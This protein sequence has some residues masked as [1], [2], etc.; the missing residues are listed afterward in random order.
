M[1]VVTGS[2]RSGTSAVAR[3]LHESG[4]CMGRDLIGPTEFNA[5][6]YYEE[7]AVVALNDELLAEVGLRPSRRLLPRLYR[8][9]RRA[10]GATEVPAPRWSAV[11]RAQVLA[12]ARKHS[13]RMKQLVAGLP[14]GGGWKDPRFSVTLE[15]WLPHLPEKPRLIVCLRSPAAVTASVLRIYGLIDTEA[16]GDPASPQ[17]R[18]LLR[19]LERV[20][21]T[22]EERWSMQ[23]RWLLE[24]IRDFELEA[25]CVEYD[26]LIRDPEGTV[27]ALAEFVG[28]P[29]DARYVERPFRH[30]A[31][32]V[33]ERFVELYQRVLALAGGRASAQREPRPL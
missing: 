22:T 9:L 20:S 2:G 18:K 8:R 30:Y 3:V 29:L 4:I 19:Y 10:L 27:A 5:E 24:F 32:G 7:R 25:T 23:Y 11:S 6:G 1:I 14:P 26:A 21:E 12:A 31:A 28:R 33:P 13:S 15:A 17:Y 16:A